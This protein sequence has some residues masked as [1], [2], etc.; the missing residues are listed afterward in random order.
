MNRSVVTKVANGF[1]LC[2]EFFVLFHVFFY[3]VA[4]FLLISSSVVYFMV[5]AFRFCSR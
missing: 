1:Y 2:K 5:Y 4:V 3:F